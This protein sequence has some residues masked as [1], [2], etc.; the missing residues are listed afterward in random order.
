MLYS[1]TYSGDMHKPPQ[2]LA[3]DHGV[4]PKLMRGRKFP[5]ATLRLGSVPNPVPVMER[6]NEFPAIHGEAGV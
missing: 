3:P 2:L 6:V 5:P 4:A 1:H